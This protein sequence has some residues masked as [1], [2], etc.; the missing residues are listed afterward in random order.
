LTH[1]FELPIGGL[2]GS[3]QRPLVQSLQAVENLWKRRSHLAFS[4][5]EFAVQVFAGQTS[6]PVR[7]PTSLVRSC[8]VSVEASGAAPFPSHP[9]IRNGAKTGRSKAISAFSTAQVEFLIYMF[10]L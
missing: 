10:D 6:L 2:L 9:R 5:E 8:S 4:S 7:L 1:R 3:L